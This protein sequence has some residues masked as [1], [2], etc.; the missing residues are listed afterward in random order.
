MT[1]RNPLIPGRTRGH[2]PRLQC[3]TDEIF[4]VSRQK[5]ANSEAIRPNAFQQLANDLLTQ[6]T[7]P[8]RWVDRLDS[9]IHPTS[10]G[11]FEL[12]D[13]RSAA[14]PGRCAQRGSRPDNRVSLPYSEGW[15]RVVHGFQIVGAFEETIRVQILSPFQ[16]NCS[17][18]ASAARRTHEL[19]GIF[20]VAARID[21]NGIRGMQPSQHIFS[22]R[23]KVAP[24]LHLEIAGFWNRSF[25][26]HRQTGSSPRVEAAVQN[27]HILVPEEFQEPKKRAERIPATSS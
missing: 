3:I 5:L 19:S 17:G 11:S 23:Q 27:M 18:N 25:V 10:R 15:L 2:R 12:G 21:K 6:E 9:P 24:G 22:R 1:A 16:M 8:F 20:V 7:T 14:A 26:G 13:S 4:R